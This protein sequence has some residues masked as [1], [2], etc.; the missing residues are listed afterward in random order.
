MAIL[1]AGLSAQQQRPATLPRET[2]ATF[3]P[4]T[5]S[6][7]YIRREVMIPMRDGVKLHTV[8]LVPR[9]AAKSADPAD[10]HPL[11]RDHLTTHRAISTDI[12]EF[13]ARVLVIQGQGAP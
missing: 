12:L 13:R 2:P 9:G 11:Q 6:F 7:D 8:I 10:T 3:R 5:D 4:A 1:A